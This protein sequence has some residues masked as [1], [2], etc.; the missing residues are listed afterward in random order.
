MAKAITEALP[1]NDV[2]LH[3][4]EVERFSKV[5]YELIYKFAP[6]F[7]KVVFEL[8]KF[9]LLRKIFNLYIGRVYEPQLKKIM[10]KEK[11]DI[12]I[13]TYFAF[14]PFLESLELK[15]GFKFIN[16][17]ADPLTFS[18]VLISTRAMNLVFDDY[19]FRK[20]K[21]LNSH[22][23]GT[24]IGWFTEKKFYES[25]RKLRK[26]VRK[27]LGFNPKK[28]TLCITTG[29]E[30]T[31]NVFKILKTLL[32]PKYKIQ[33]LIMCGN[34][35]GMLKA[36]KTF[37]PISK[38]IGGPE[39]VA[40]PYTDKVEK[41]LRA[42][43]LVIGKAGPNTIFESV[44]T[45]TPFFAVSHV[46]GQED[47][48]LEIIKRYKIGFVEERIVAAT[49]KLEEI[50]ENPKLL[51]KF[52]KNLKALSAYNQNSERKIFNLLRP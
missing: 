20:M 48:N 29:S 30:G 19:S 40:I 44:A 9:K 11:P 8:S 15:S 50:I 49:K 51:N 3:F 7:F 27:E 38:K 34:N 36:I 41:Y 13:N 32:D 4:I 14:N 28:F 24:P 47:G 2:N 1:G 10:L 33:V 35:T 12:V 43:D 17:L 42:S 31:F 16:V 18:G 45:L 22:A 25:Q 26:N 21:S 5:S 52:Q 37:I 39:I 6:N 46:A 23:D